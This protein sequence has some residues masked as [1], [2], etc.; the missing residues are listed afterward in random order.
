MARILKGV[1]LSAAI[2]LLVLTSVAAPASAITVELAKKCRDMAI[3]AHPPA[4]PG[5][6]KG[7]A[8]AEREFYRSCL[9]NGGTGSDDDTQKGAPPPAK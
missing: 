7:S 1:G 2:T 8:Q 5:T 6:K 9:S 3:K 4:L